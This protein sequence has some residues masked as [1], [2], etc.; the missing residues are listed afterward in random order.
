MTTCPGSSNPLLYSIFDPLGPS[1]I[2][3][4]TRI[5]KNNELNNTH[6]GDILS[7]KPDTTTRLYSQNQ[8][9]CNLKD[10]GYQ[11]KEL[12]EDTLLI[13]ADIRSIIEHN[14]D[15]TSMAVRQTYLEI[16][17]QTFSHFSLEMTSS[18]IPFLTQYK[19]GGTM[20]LTQDNITG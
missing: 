19:P 9:G 2:N 1:S 15:T 8:N 6:V 16:A 5:R 17:K 7:K 11:F 20:I 14:L 13:Q 4:E 18:M 3:K 12:C 10:K